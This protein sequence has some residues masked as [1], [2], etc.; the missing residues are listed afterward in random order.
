MSDPLSERALERLLSMAA[1]DADDETQ[2]GPLLPERYRVV[3][4]IGRG[5]M[6]VVFECD[7]RTLQRRCAVKTLGAGAGAD[8]EQR[9]RFAREAL[10]AARL[11]HPNIAAVYDATED[12]ISM[13]L[14]HG[15]PIDA[16]AGGRD[17]RTSVERVRDAARALHHAHE[18]GIVHRDVKPSN[19][20]VEDG[21]V[22]VVD[23]GLA[24]TH[25]HDASLSL[26]GSVVGTPAFMAPE[27]ALGEPSIDPRADV[28]G[29]GATLF[30]CLRGR[31][32]FEADDLPALLRKVVE[33]HP[34]RVGVD[35]DLDIVIGKCLQKEPEQRYDTAAD[36]ADDLDRWLSDQPIH[37]RPPSIWYRCKKQL[38]RQRLLWRAAGVAAL[39]TA[40]VLVPIAM[41]AAAAR[42]AATEAAELTDHVAA[43]FEDAMIYHRLGDSTSARTVCDDGIERVR[44]YLRRHDVPRVRYLLGRL[45][46]FVGRTDDA[47]A[48]LTRVIE[49]DPDFTD[50]RFERG[51]LQASQLAFPE[52]DPDAT[53]TAVADLAVPPGP[54][55]ALTR[56]DRLLGRAERHRLSGELDDADSMLQELLEY[57]P[58]NV[59]ARLALSRIAIDRGDDELA[60]YY[61]ASAVDF[62]QGFGPIYLARQRRTL[63]TSMLGLDGA[64]LDFTPAL[65]DGLD[66][67]YA[68]AYRGLVHLRRAL[69][70]S[71]EGSLADA[72]QAVTQA[73]EDHDT[74][75][76][77][78]TGV[79]GAY[80]N[81]AV[82][83]LVDADFAARAEDE[84]ARAEA[85]R[86]ANID[87]E[88]A[89]ELDD[90]IAEAHYNLAVVLQLR[91]D[92]LRAHGHDPTATD[93][94]A[95]ESLRAAL[96][97][98]PDRWPHRAACERRLR[99]SRR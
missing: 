74:T 57:E 52:V 55:S 68:M 97:R 31:P 65:E 49:Q 38:Q 28:Y 64:L 77:I 30:A 12:Y 71:R 2:P 43:L 56:I 58:G 48:E 34:P 82:C 75:L 18:Q 70:L 44:E 4:E 10:A 29:L 33:A 53:A 91:A 26:A 73:L 83:R 14:V 19:L 46:Q 90:R 45:L 50:A 32:P 69:R 66:H 72:R 59:S 6:G 85:M 98:M 94:A 95:A 17:A 78:H 1:D 79:A 5:G 99:E 42:T 92:R 39:L 93:R 41:Q 47:L 15:G 25:G 63:P 21:Q 88:R 20:L 84:A 13:Q 35:R 96:A 51:M 8:A 16:A 37:A 22:F 23:F 80:N 7:D 9:R 62:Q 81:R 87:L 27:Q 76:Q 36:L 24:K 11:R 40:L 54:R 86:R 61:A 89:I 67:G 3:R 60:P